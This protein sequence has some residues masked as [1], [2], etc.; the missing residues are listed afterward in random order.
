MSARRPVT[1]G[2]GPVED[3]TPRQ[4]HGRVAKC[5]CGGDIGVL[6]R[7]RQELP[8]SDGAIEKAR[9]VCGTP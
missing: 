6:R 4:V 8:E 2:G 1:E 5:F 7:R 9:S 3:M